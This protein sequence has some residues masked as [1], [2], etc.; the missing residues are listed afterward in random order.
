MKL[1]HTQP[2]KMF[3]ITPNEIAYSN[4]SLGKGDTLVYPLQRCSL[5]GFPK[6]HCPFGCQR[7]I[8]LFDNF[9]K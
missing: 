1:S 5:K 4:E 3:C 8:K 9:K 6:G 2:E 7:Q